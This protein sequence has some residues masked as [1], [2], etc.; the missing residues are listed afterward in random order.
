MENSKIGCSSGR[1][2]IIDPNHFGGE[3]SSSNIP[4]NNE[5]L[6]ISVVLTT[7]KKGRTILTADK[8][9]SK[10]TIDTQ[11][12]VSINFIDGSNING[13][14]VLTTNYTDLTTIFDD[15]TSSNAG[16]GLGITSIDIDFNSQQAPLVT[17]Q[18]VDVRGTAIFQNEQ[19]IMGGKN[20]Y[21]TFFQLPYPLFKLT[22]KGY[23]GLPVQ[24]CLHMY[25]FNS[26]F[27]SQTGNFEI[28][29]NFIGFTYAMLSDM[30]IGY[31]K[32]IPYTNIGK[33]RYK[34]I[35]DARRENGVEDIMNLN[36]LMIAIALINESVKQLSASD[37]DA[38]EVTNI[39]N[40]TSSLN[41]IKDILTRFCS[42]LDIRGNTTEITPV[43]C[44]PD[45]S[46]KDVA[47]IIA[48]YTE[49]M[50]KAIT[51][52]N[53]NS[54]VQLDVTLFDMNLSVSSNDNGRGFPNNTS[55]SIRDA[56]ATVPNKVNVALINADLD[57][58]ETDKIKDDTICTFWLMVQPKRALEEAAT[59]LEDAKKAA[60]LSLGVKARDLIRTKLKF[61]PTM[62]NIIEIF[63]TA[64]EV[65]MESIYQ[66][67]S[68]AEKIPNKLR[69]DQLIPKFVAKESVDI[70]NVKNTDESILAWPGY[71]EKKDQGNK[72]AYVEKYLGQIKPTKILEIPTDVDEIRFI[73]DLLMGFIAAAAAT[74]QASEI[75]NETENIWFPISPVD[76]KLFNINSFPY[77]RIG[78]TGLSSHLEVAN[79]L[80]IRATTFLNGNNW[81]TER[82]VEQMAEMDTMSMIH[83][84]DDI[85]L[86]LALSNLTY[87][88]FLTLKGK[89]NDKERDILFKDN[90]DSTYVYTYFPKNATNDTTYSERVLPISDGFSGTWAKD[91]TTGI[92]GFSGPDDVVFLTNYG[93]S[94]TLDKPIDGGVYIKMFTI[95]DYNAYAN[96]DSSVKPADVDV[97][98]NTLLLTGLQTDINSVTA[99]ETAKFNAFGGP[100]GVQEFKN[101]DWGDS[102]LDKLP[103]RFLFFNKEDSK[104]SGLVIHNDKTDKTDNSFNPAA[105]TSPFYFGWW[106]TNYTIIAGLAVQPADV[107][108]DS[109]NRYSQIGKNYLNLNNSST[110]PITYPFVTQKVYIPLKNIG[111]GGFSNYNEYR[112]IS[113]FGNQWFYGQSNSTSPLYAKA[114]LFL[115]SLPW[116][117]DPLVSKETLNLFNVRAGFV[118]VPKL[119]AAYVG[120]LIWRNDGNNPITSN[121]IIT[122]GGSGAGDPIVWQITGRVLAPYN[123]DNS[124]ANTKWPAT[125]QSISQ[126]FT[127]EQQQPDLYGTLN[128]ILSLPDQVKEEFKKVFFNFVHKDSV[129]IGKTTGTVYDFN[130]LNE[131]SQIT[132]SGTLAGFYAASAPIYNRIDAI[133]TALP[134]N[135]QVGYQDGNFSEL[136]GNVPNFTTSHIVQNIHNYENYQVITPFYHDR[137]FPTNVLHFELEYK[138]GADKAGSPANMIL[139]MLQ[140]EIVIA[141]ASPYIWDAVNTNELYAP[142]FNTVDRFEKY[143][144]TVV[145]VL[146][147]KCSTNAIA[148]DLK[149]KE[150]EIFGTSDS[151]AIKF[152][153]YKTCKNINDKWLGGVTNIDNIVYQC[154][155][156]NS[157]VDKG[158]RKKYRRNDEKARLIDSFRFVDRAFSDIGDLFY[159][160]PIPVNDYLMNSPNTSVFDAV[161]Q[162]LASNHFTFIPLPT[163]INYNDPVMLK[164]MFNTYPDYGEAIEDGICGPSFVSVY[165]GDTSK[166]LD[167]GD[168]EYPNDG[169][170]FQC[171]SNNSIINVPPDFVGTSNEFENDVAIFSVNYGQQNQNIF[172]DIT[173]DQSEFSETDESLKITDD[174]GHKGVQ[175]DI[176]LG[177]Q[178]IYN[179][180]SVRSYKAEVEMMGNAMIQ[181][182]MHFQLNNIPMFHGAYLIT[183][184]KHTIKPNYMST[185]FSGSRVRYPKTELLSGADFYMGILDSMNLS[186]NGSNTVGAVG[187]SLIN[188]YAADLRANI[189]K[190]KII[191]GSTIPNKV[192]LTQRAEKELL[193]WQDGK[194]NEKNGVAFLDEY[195]KA[196][197]ANGV[198]GTEYAS[199][200]QPWSGVFISYVMLAGDSDFPNSAMH[201]SYIT[202]A[203]NG[204]NGYEA[205]ALGS[206]L[207]IKPEVGDLI[208]EPRPAGGTTGGHCNVLYKTTAT[209]ASFVGGNLSS[210][211][212]KIDVTLDGGY[213]TDS[214]D[215]KKMV[216]YIKKTDNKYYNKKKIIGTGNFDDGVHKGNQIDTKTLYEEL[217]KQLGY[218]DAAIAGIMG[219]MYQESRFIPT[220]RNPV[221][222]DYGLVQWYGP[223]QEALLK[224]LSDN[225]LDKTYF[226]DQIQYLKH[227]ITDKSK[228]TGKN[229]AANND[230]TDATKIFY[231]T[232]ESGTLGYFNFS[233][234]SVAERLAEMNQVDGS[235]NKRVSYATQISEMIKTK[236]FYIPR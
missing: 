160:N 188:G 48:D 83:S 151:D 15:N 205:F 40:K 215:V 49:E 103:L 214:T 16:E 67:S 222:K 120:G 57:T 97:T 71:R 53:Q 33:Q 85:T 34:I 65:F 166:H 101:L 105:P 66:V 64:V 73:D 185:V 156:A 88:S 56:I 129:S 78:K 219:N 119:W 159:L 178:N 94:I 133:D 152:Q 112:N 75:I 209:V 216:I 180:Y 7:F 206:G 116:A 32:A 58:L 136:T 11:K 124:I 117:T 189:P 197:P 110:T 218:G 204:K 164:S 54:N 29:A 38:I 201:F 108:N 200:A 52:F 93:N 59:Q 27:N 128:R 147:D 170:D 196:T 21:S 80:L 165:A 195:A 174:I 202:D 1:A 44:K 106:G 111:G 229:L 235:Y 231:I 187:S 107:T 162:L 76:T 146:K 82:E 72:E 91:T 115:N 19:N 163:F 28:T 98:K 37:T 177:G 155:G 184:V 10:N 168:N 207:K 144:K 74:Q 41:N 79:L 113:V 23:Y 186:A 224:W 234:N 25:K 18:F 89:I 167:F 132:S 139:T 203:M 61:D 228:Y 190:N 123:N 145:N 51:E 126:I 181:P 171:G 148:D 68:D 233:A 179:V 199:G 192:A 149:Q 193:N 9:T 42:Q 135:F 169:V 4:V 70:N 102:T 157:S 213:I 232:Y 6:N 86:K 5:D 12:S 175:N 150:Q 63:T 118:H 36:D 134:T 87:D 230:V 173:L 140:E 22:I 60:R 77:K 182:M 217:K 161:S 8:T 35:N 39:E 210:S 176:S 137:I 122:G 81:L 96:L 208:C 3:N 227:D 95:D 50:N 221:G 158:L 138:D 191:E 43:I 31:L 24:Y 198:S 226:K 99:A 13:K 62:R 114:L 225:G 92:W 125:N 26:K 45:S 131:A 84:I 30:L 212:K 90:T 69:L 172:K 153:L 141:N 127:D 55:K 2:T 121:G 154:G 211:A 194:V 223:A 17:I 142:M 143:F 46:V 100:W 47:K 236:N 220:A 20:K 183:R 104:A 130:D 14:Q 109:G